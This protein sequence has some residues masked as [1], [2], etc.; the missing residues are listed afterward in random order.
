MDAP[1]VTDPPPTAQSKRQ[2]L[3]TKDFREAIAERKAVVDVGCE[4]F[5][6]KPRT[7]ATDFSWNNL[8]PSPVRGRRSIGP[9]AS[10]AQ[11]AAS[12][13]AKS[14][15]EAATEEALVQPKLSDYICVQDTDNAH[16]EVV[17]DK[18]MASVNDLSTKASSADKL[19]ATREEARRVNQELQE[20][21]T[22][23]VAATAV[24]AQ[25]SVDAKLAADKVACD[26]TEWS[27]CDDDEFEGSNQEPVAPEVSHASQLCSA[28][29][30]VVSHA[31]TRN[32][33]AT[34]HEDVWED[35]FSLCDELKSMRQR[36]KRT[37]QRSVRFAEARAVQSGV[38]KDTQSSRALPAGNG[39]ISQLH[40]SVAE[41]AL[42]HGLGCGLGQSLGHALTSMPK[43]ATNSAR[44]RLAS[45]TKAAS[46]RWAPAA[47][48][49]AQESKEMPSAVAPLGVPVAVA[50]WPLKPWL[51]PPR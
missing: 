38:D 12:V 47:R 31:R 5:E 32:L 13:D 11:P 50:H 41:S 33:A 34:C 49:D 35:L 26:I 37:A 15:P 28:I 44:S 23:A 51:P 45:S 42:Y 25:S 8:P 43:P 3:G 16:D 22:E 24:P 9:A 18:S 40:D 29:S 21:R 19:E 14:A 17:A 2:S 6:N 20:A 39:P 36:N 4:T 1:L 48:K 46:K 27:I 30:A 10:V 7:T